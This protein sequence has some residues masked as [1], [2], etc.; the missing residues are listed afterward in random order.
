MIEVL[1][2]LSQ[3]TESQCPHR[4]RGIRQFNYSDLP[5]WDIVCATSGNPL[6]GASAKVQS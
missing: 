5:R 1:G 2:Y 6:S 4:V 3:R